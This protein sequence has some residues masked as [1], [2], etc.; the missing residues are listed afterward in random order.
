VCYNNF[1]TTIKGFKI[2]SLVLHVDDSFYS[3]LLSFLNQNKPQVDILE[4]IK[5]DGYPSISKEEA[6]TRV[7]AAVEEYKNGKMT[8][9]SYT[10]GMDKIDEWLNTL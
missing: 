7:S 8:T 2:H 5:D 6:K 9:V 4:D 1:T 3:Q 10:Q